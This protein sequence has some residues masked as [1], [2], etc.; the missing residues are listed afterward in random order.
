MNA[1]YYTA[2]WRGGEAWYAYALA[3]SMAEAGLKFSFVAARVEPVEREVNHPNVRRRYILSGTGGRRS[4]G[5]RAVVNLYRLLQ[6]TL[7]LLGERFQTRTFLVTHPPHWLL[8]TYLQ[9]L[10]L[11]ITGA[12]IIYIVHDAR[13][14][15][16]AFPQNLRGLEE[17]M[18]A[19]TYVLSAHIIVL[20]KAA[21]K[22]LVDCFKI[23]ADKIDVV[24]HGAFST[25]EPSPLPGDGKVLL[26]GMLR[27]NKRVRDSIEA[28]LL[29]GDELPQVKLV[30]AGAPYAG[31]RDYWDEC[32]SLIAKKPD[33]FITEIGFVEEV[34]VPELFDLSDAVLL[35]Y[36]DFNSQSGVAVLACLARRPIMSTGVGGIGEL[37]EEGLANQVVK[38]PVTALSIRD[39]LR[40]F[41]SRPI[42]EWRQVTNS[43]SKAIE[44]FLSWPRIAERIIQIIKQGS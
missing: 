24:P 39:A 31:E 11:R 7:R 13:P 22:D 23:D 4:A 17:W 10:L 16:W 21:K 30:I 8:A 41:Y 19:Q 20:T 44:E 29:L 15:A 38:Q 6:I 35:P 18:L 36:E 27:R 26:F 32:A 33:R 9:F 14:H 37:V 40:Q 3:Q 5:L 25:G 43:S 1:C 42:E 2:A 34:R 28:M 12:R